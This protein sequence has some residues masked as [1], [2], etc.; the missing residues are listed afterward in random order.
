MDPPLCRVDDFLLDIL[1]PAWRATRDEVVVDLDFLSCS[2][3]LS[4]FSAEKHSTNDCT[5]A[6]ERRACSITHVLTSGT[7]SSRNTPPVKTAITESDTASGTT[8]GEDSSS[9]LG[10]FLFDSVD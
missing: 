6:G 5:C 9:V 1:D 7:R 2:S 3:K 4:W 8:E 10:V